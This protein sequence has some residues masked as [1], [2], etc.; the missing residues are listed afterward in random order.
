MF[1][2][3]VC[4]FQNTCR[5]QTIQIKHSNTNFYNKKLGQIQIKCKRREIP[6]VSVSL[7]QKHGQTN[8]FSHIFTN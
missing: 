5:I 4:I 1:E 8:K 3:G 7:Q 6:L 2:R